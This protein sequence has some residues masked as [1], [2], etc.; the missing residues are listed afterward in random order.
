MVKLAEVS[1]SRETLVGKKKGSDGDVGK[2]YFLVEE[3]FN[4]AVNSFALRPVLV[5]NNLGKKSFNLL[6]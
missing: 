3:Y 2:L 6:F 5:T 4:V 1:F